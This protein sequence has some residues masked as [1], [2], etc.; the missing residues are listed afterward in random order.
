MVPLGGHLDKMAAW[1]AGLLLYGWQP[2]VKMPSDPLGLCA[3]VGER[4]VEGYSGREVEVRLLGVGLAV[5]V[6]TGACGC[7]CYTVMG[8]LTA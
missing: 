2:R 5:A 1:M 3:H 6:A 4:G 8:S 7:H